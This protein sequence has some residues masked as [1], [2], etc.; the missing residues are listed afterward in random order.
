MTFSNGRPLKKKQLLSNNRGDNWIT[1]GTE[2]QSCWKIWG[3]AAE[4]I[5][6]IHV[7]LM[8]DWAAD[9]RC[10]SPGQVSLYPWWRQQRR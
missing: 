8:M 4:Q 3:L 1:H 9:I 7:P 6:E 2:L 10:H 5:I